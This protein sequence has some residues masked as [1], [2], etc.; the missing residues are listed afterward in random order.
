MWHASV[1][2]RNPFYGATLCRQRAETALSGLGDP[3]LGEWHEW[4]GTTFHIR[5]RL[6]ATEQERVGPALDIRRTPEAR[7]RARQLGDRLAI[8]PESVLAD[9]VGHAA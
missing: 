7:R 4:S 3:M 8:V 2:P 1:R 5:R 6:T 9:E